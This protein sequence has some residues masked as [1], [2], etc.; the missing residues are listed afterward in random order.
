ME[1]TILIFVEG[2]CLSL[3]KTDNRSNGMRAIV[4]LITIGRSEFLGL[5]HNERSWKNDG[6]RSTKTQRNSR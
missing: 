4:F 2:Y 1:L 6:R 5:G 3:L